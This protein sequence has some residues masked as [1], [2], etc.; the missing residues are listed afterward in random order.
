MLSL[1][2]L[3][4]GW[5]SVLLA[6]SVVGVCLRQR[7]FLSY[8][9][10]NLVLLS[11]ALF[12]LACYYVQAAFGFDSYQYYYFYYTGDTIGNLLIYVLIGWFFDRLLRDSVFHRYVRPTLILAFVLIVGISA[13]FL[14]ANLENFYSKF[15][16]EFQQNVYFV[17]VLLT[18]LLWI[19]LNYL[20]VESRRFVLL[21]SGLGIYFSAHA[22]GYATRFLLPGLDPLSARFPPLAYDM[23]LCLWLYT[24][25]V[26]PESERVEERVR[27]QLQGAGSPGHIQ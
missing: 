4:I 17:G 6:L 16:F 10:L 22:V 3:G 19:S 18:L 9:F 2:D 24:F 15:V 13:R 12:T 25:L 14:S 1:I 26:V 20:Q 8:F 23:M 27:V 5:L 21:V 7:C 11:A